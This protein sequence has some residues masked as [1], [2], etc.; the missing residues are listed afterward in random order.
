MP[1]GVPDFLGAD[2]G[3]LDVDPE[4][5]PD[6]DPEPVVPLLY[7]AFAAAPASPATLPAFL[8]ARTAVPA[9]LQARP[10]PPTT[11]F[12]A[13]EPAAFDCFFNHSKFLIEENI[14]FLS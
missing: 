14:S 13:T 3:A 8:T 10:A 11:A 1:A 9:A 6:V 12:L 7:P 5:E 4:V 2:A